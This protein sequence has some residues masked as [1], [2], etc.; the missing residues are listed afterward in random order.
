[1][2]LRLNMGV[3]LPLL[4]LFEVY[5]EEVINQIL[6]FRLVVASLW[7]FTR[8]LGLLRLCVRP[9]RRL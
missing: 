2:N 3:I 6:K 8:R 7:V 5:S 1:M 4:H 9:I